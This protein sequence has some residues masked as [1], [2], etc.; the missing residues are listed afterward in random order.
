MGTS[1]LE[2]FRKLVPKTC[3]AS[4]TVTMATENMHCIC[5]YKKK[6]KFKTFMQPPAIKKRL[7]KNITK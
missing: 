2:D 7:K 1:N 5:Q 3:A 4:L 6:V